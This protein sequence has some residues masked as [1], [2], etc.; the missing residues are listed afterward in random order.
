MIKKI[1]ITAI[2]SCLV[3]FLIVSCTNKNNKK[4][5]KIE[6]IYS[7]SGISISL[8]KEEARE[9]E[10]VNYV[11]NI[12]NNYIFSSLELVFNNESY[13]LDKNTRSFKMPDAPV[14]LI[15]NAN[16]VSDI[17]N[18]IT[19]YSSYVPYKVPV[20]L[21]DENP[22][23]E[24]LVKKELDESLVEYSLYSL[25]HK[26]YGKNVSSYSSWYYKYEDFVKTNLEFDFNESF[27]D[28]FFVLISVSNKKEYYAYSGFIDNS[29]GIYINSQKNETTQIVNSIKT[30]EVY[31]YVFL[32]PSFDYIGGDICEY[33]TEYIVSGTVATIYFN[34][35]D[36]RYIEN[37]LDASNIFFSEFIQKY[38]ILK[39]Y[40]YYYKENYIN[41]YVSN[42]KILKNEFEI[43]FNE[44]LRDDNFLLYE[45]EI[46]SDG[47]YY[48]SKENYDEYF[49]KIQYL[50]LIAISSTFSNGDIFIDSYAKMEE[51][52][53]EAGI[54][55]YLDYIKNNTNENMPYFD[56]TFF[57][58][59]NLLVF[60]FLELGASLEYSVGVI[61]KE[62]DTLLIGL[63][64]IIPD[65]LVASNMLYVFCFLPLQKET[66][67]NI[68]VSS[69][70][71]NLF[72]SHPSNLFYLSLF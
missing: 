34:I 29:L 22:F 64:N 36:F 16:L 7:L 43:L 57:E 53:G 68:V 26:L 65:N 49:F 70:N 11:L 67:T 33:N 39:D 54:S 71:T 9:N 12:N 48:S 31:A 13:F 40:K 38:Q 23:P 69:Y 51:I 21:D 27:F 3:L 32:K 4:L 42:L 1:A 5:H 61:K 52:L 10:T 24:Y 46:Q 14:V 56:S 41:I 50:S 2:C 63:G 6:T 37:P 59:N 15:L 17:N 35:G 62:E 18:D 60:G 45:L 44:L 28:N 19:R 72:L 58:N 66:T 8:D 55:Y 47:Y 25:E 20:F 30:Y